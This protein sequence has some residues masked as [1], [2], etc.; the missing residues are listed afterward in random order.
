M[1]NITFDFTGRTV[2]DNDFE[3][4]IT[5]HAGDTF[6]FTRAAVPPYRRAALPPAAA[7]PAFPASDEAGYITGIVLP[8][9]GG[10]ST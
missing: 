8:V 3:A 10:L 7:N 9:D 4:V 6:R 1:P 2:A 5:L